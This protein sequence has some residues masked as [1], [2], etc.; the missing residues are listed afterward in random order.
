M[1]DFWAVVVDLYSFVRETLFGQG[2]SP[3]S[4]KAATALIVDTTPVAKSTATQ[5][6][7]YAEPHT[8]GL[9]S[10]G[11]VTRD[12]AVVL[13]R[14]V[15][16]FDTVIATVV[17]GTSVEVIGYQGRFVQVKIQ[18]EEG[19]LLKDDV[20]TDKSQVWPVLT[21]SA[22]Y[23]A[24]SRETQLI[25]SVIRD[26]FFAT[27]LYLPLRTEEFVTYRLREHS[28]RI[29]WGNERPR[30]AGRWHELLKGRSGIF[31]GLEPKTGS[32]MEAYTAEGEPFLAYV[33]AVEPDA[34]LTLE[35]VGKDS[36]G[37][38]LRESVP[39]SLWHEWRPVFIAVT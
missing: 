8:F 33:V 9:V 15:W 25:R 20:T 28:R 30:I 2:N 3:T 14:P 10:A 29:M 36:D 21:S 31:I 39:K 12:D 27:E 37:V 13:S 11:Y 22:T 17:Y 6:H 19:W 35:S 4:T 5:A 34:T 7:V 32:V 16:A 18:Q 26:E 1:S 38:Y 24:T 23:L